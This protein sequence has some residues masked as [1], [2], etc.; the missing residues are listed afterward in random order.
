MRD[1]STTGSRAPEP[2][3]RAAHQQAPPKLL[4]VLPERADGHGAV[5]MCLPQYRP[6][7]GGIVPGPE[8]DGAEGMPR[9]HHRERDYDDRSG[10]QTCPRVGDPLGGRR[11]YEQGSRHQKCELLREHRQGAE[12]SRQQPSV[13]SSARHRGSARPSA[14][15]SC[16]WKTVCTHI[17]TGKRDRHHKE[18]HQLPATASP[19]TRPQ[20]RD[21]PGHQGKPTDASDPG[22]RDNCSAAD[23]P[24]LRLGVDPAATG[25]ER[26]GRWERC[27][28]SDL[29]DGRD[30]AGE[31]R[32]ERR[33]WRFVRLTY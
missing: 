29:G 16:G 22:G 1:M 4:R 19:T 10:Q 32:V 31:Q 27:A 26:G 5:G 7:F 9:G 21:H 2:S 12:D 25:S 18:G 6:T 28:V 23:Q 24:T 15:K 3:R 17:H 30:A 20:P 11:Q 13:A 14:S 8:C 33:N